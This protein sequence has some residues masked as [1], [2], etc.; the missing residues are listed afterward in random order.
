MQTGT[1]TQSNK[2]SQNNN[3]HRRFSVLQAPTHDGQSCCLCFDWLADWFKTCGVTDN[4]V[5]PEK[6]RVCSHVS[7]YLCAC[8]HYRHVIFARGTVHRMHERVWWCNGTIANGRA[9]HWQIV[10][11]RE[12]TLNICVTSRA[13]AGVRSAAR[14]Y[15]ICIKSRAAHIVWSVVVNIRRQLD[16][17][18][19]SNHSVINN[20]TSR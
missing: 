9:T 12:S 11:R 2:V 4:L 7:L 20:K 14:C 3:L 15:R 10:V 8:L 19:S 1:K 6:C 5:K 16:K 17:M 18:T 13:A